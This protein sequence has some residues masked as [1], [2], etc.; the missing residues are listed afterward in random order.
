MNKEKNV[1]LINILY[2][3]RTT[4]KMNDGRNLIVTN[5]YLS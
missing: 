3:L 4:E 5:F 2:I 1:M